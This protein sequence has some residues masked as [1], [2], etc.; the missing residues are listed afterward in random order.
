MHITQI[1]LTLNRDVVIFTTE[2]F[3]RKNGIQKFRPLKHITGGYRSISR[4]NSQ[5]HDDVMTLRKKNKYIKNHSHGKETSYNRVH[6][7]ARVLT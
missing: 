1:T 6:S 5:R 2:N 3:A 4:R 7:V